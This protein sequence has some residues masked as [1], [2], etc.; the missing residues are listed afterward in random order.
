MAKLENFLKVR[1]DKKFV[2]ESTKRHD[3]VNVVDDQCSTIDGL[4]HML[5]IPLLPH[6]LDARSY[7]FLLL[8]RYKQTVV[9][10]PHCCRIISHVSNVKF[11]ERSA[12]SSLCRVNSYTIIEMTKAQTFATTFGILHRSWKRL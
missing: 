6:E 4:K 8:D 2:H 11:V 10:L 9:L 7:T 3:V 12:L 1:L 5:V